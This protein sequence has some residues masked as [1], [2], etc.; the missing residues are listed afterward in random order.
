MA[1]KPNMCIIT[2]TAETGMT[3]AM[4]IPEEMGE[5]Y[6]Y[7]IPIPWGCRPRAS[8]HTRALLTPRPRV[9][10]Q[11]SQSPP[12]H[13]Y[14][15]PIQ[16]V[17]PIAAAQVQAAAPAPQSPG[18]SAGETMQMMMMNGMMQQQMQAQQMNAIQMTAMLRDTGRGGGGGGGHGGGSGTSINNNNNNNNNNNANNNNA[19]SNNNNGCGG[20]CCGSGCA[21]RRPARRGSMSVIVEGRYPSLAAAL[22]LGPGLRSKYE[23]CGTH[24][25]ADQQASQNPSLLRRRHHRLPS[26]SIAEA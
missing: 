18:W 10:V 14:A 25:V 24:H 4:G 11:Q 7:H 16:P 17:Q 3:M 2:I 8:A 9:Q 1:G 21:R 26:P 15:Q 22:T 6:R 5:S 12:V 19:N 13:Q 23:Q 20:G